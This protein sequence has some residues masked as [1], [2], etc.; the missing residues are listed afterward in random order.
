M[1]KFEGGERK[2]RLEKA[3]GMGDWA[4]ELRLLWRIY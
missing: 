3:I 1:R 2:D 4:D